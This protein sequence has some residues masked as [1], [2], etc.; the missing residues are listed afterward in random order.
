VNQNNCVARLADE[1]RARK[2]DKCALKTVR[3]VDLPGTIVGINPVLAGD[4]EHLLPEKS[5]RPGTNSQQDIT[6]DLSLKTHSLRGAMIGVSKGEKSNSVAIRLMIAFV[7]ST[8][9]LFECQW[10]NGIL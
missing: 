1:E 8:L 2:C 10:G 3:R 6:E 7:R 5:S 9:V 4:I